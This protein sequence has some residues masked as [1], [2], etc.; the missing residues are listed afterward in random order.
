M[1]VVSRKE[2]AEGNRIV[3]IG[4]VVFIA[5]YIIATIFFIILE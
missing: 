1:N 2:K 4:L 5:V 3:G